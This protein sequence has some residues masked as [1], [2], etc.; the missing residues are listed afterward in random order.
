VDEVGCGVVAG[1]AG[2]V[3]DGT[4]VVAD[5]TGALGRLATCGGGV[6]WLVV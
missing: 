4:G 2:V 1:G 6:A 3:A 5:G